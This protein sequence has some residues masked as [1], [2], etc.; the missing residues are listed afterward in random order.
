MN[1]IKHADSPRYVKLHESDNVAV[2]V[3]DQ[4]VAEGSAFPDGLCVIESV[5]QS[6]K[7]ALEDIGEGEP[8]R[9]Y[10]Q[11]IGY[12]LAPIRRGSWVRETLLQMPSAPPLDQ[13][14]MS[15]AVPAPLEPL[16]G[17]TFEG[18]RNADGTVGTRNILGITTTVQCVTGV[19]DHAVERIHRELLPRYPNVDDV[20]ALTHSYGCGVAITAK[21]AYIPIRTVRNLAR[22]PNLGGEALVISLGCEKLQADQIMHADDS[23]VDLDDP[24]L[25]RLQDSGTGFA[26]MIEQIMAMAEARLIKLDRRRRETVPASE[27]IL[28]MQ[29]GG[30]DAFS[31][32]TA[33]PALG[34][35]SDLLIRAGATVMFSEVT[36][37]RDAIYMLTSRAETPEIAAALVREMDWYDQYLAKGEA[38]RSANTTPGNKKGGLSNI[39]EK[40]LGSIVKSGSS[41]INGVLGPGERVSRKGLIFC[42]TPASDFVCG[43]LQLAAGMNM[44]VFTT[45]RGTP[46]GLAMAPV[47]KVSTRT[48]LASRWPDLIDVDA[49]RIATGRSSIEELGWELF[50]YY[51]DV[52]SGRQQTSAERLRLHNDITLFNPAPIT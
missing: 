37:V 32:I 22:N 48:E 34:Y 35:A 50:H 7:V 4:G 19:L 18:Y 24:W 36:E 52:A 46:Y 29:C 43:T 33:N 10:G 13:L 20:L 47:V 41:A 21:D 15:N 30:S 44:H 2:V 45:G 40:S 9:R 51:L 3:N 23:S 27:L 17:F 42:A 26:E 11:I 39:V 14:P 38:D 28:G 25:Y 8:V 49:G 16:Q 31:G 5:P 6:H 12:A 1:L